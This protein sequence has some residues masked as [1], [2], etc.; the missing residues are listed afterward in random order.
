MQ[1][2]C[3]AFPCKEYIFMKDKA[4]WSWTKSTLRYITE[5]VVNVFDWPGNSADLT[6]IGEV[7]NIMKKKSGKLPN[8]KKTALE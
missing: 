7:W 1:V 6:P 2:E 3:V 5:R 8:I 4:P